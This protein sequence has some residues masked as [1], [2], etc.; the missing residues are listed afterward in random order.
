[1]FVDHNG[2]FLEK[3]FLTKGVGGSK[4]ELDVIQETPKNVSSPTKPV[5]DVQNVVHYIAEAP[6][7]CRYTRKHDVTQKSTLLTTE[8]R[9]I[10][11]LD[12]DEPATYKEATMG[13]DSD[14]L[15]GAM[16]SE[17]QFMHDNQVYNLID[18]INGVRPIN[19]KWVYKKKTDMDGNVHI[20]KA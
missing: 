4:V 15:L 7:P 14:K 17:I 12:N 1:V 20:Y 10:L 16:E 11:L 2:V 3:V 13:P 18:P 19:C 6:A 9:G 8:H 5:Q